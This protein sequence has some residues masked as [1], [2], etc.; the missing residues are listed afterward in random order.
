MSRYLVTGGLGFIG[1]GL[2]NTLRA[3]GHRVRII[4][5]LSSGHRDSV[6]EDCE[7]LI[8]DVNDSTLVSNAM[9]GVDGCF[10]LATPDESRAQ[11]S[12]DLGCNSLQGMINILTAAKAGNGELPVPLVYAS[13]SITYG[14]NAHTS[15]HED[16]RTRPLTSAA[17][18]K[19]TIELR[20]RVAS[21]AHGIPTTGLRLFSIYG[22]QPNPDCMSRKGVVSIFLDNI[23]NGRPITI[24]G[25][26][27]Q[28]RDFVYVSDAIKFFI[29]A[30]AR[31]LRQPSIYN[32][33]TGRQTSLRQLA[34]MMYSL[35]GGPV[36]IRYAS[37]RKGDIRTSFGNPEQA[38]R[39][40]GLR[41]GVPLAEGLQKM[42]SY[43]DGAAALLNRTS[44]SGADSLDIMSGHTVAST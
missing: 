41:A 22:P 23:L 44:T 12:D 8:G 29:N 10:H 7:V 2:A 25:D 42:L 43:R 17:A 28:T 13:S 9:S 3:A 6:H 11:D 27:H 14:D 32:V 34:G 31:P 36:D 18:D 35:C 40:L 1:S 20:A 4:D 33:C 5:N 15:L 39:L 30:M 16:V 21:L 38:I 37:A 24:Y 26:G 19:A